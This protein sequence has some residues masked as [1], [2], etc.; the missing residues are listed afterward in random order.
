[1][2]GK[3]PKLSVELKTK[4]A[5]LLLEDSKNGQLTKGKIKEVALLLHISIRSVTSIWAATKV[6][7][8]KGEPVIFNTTKW[9]K[10][11]DSAKVDW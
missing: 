8:R 11:G 1:M 3:V 2:R 9:S 7:I 10:H 5:Q 6:K 4:A